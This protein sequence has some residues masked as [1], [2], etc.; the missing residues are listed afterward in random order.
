MVCGVIVK[1]WRSPLISVKGK[2]NSD[3]YIEFKKKM[4]FTHH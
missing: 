4:I 2:L 3:G 1:G